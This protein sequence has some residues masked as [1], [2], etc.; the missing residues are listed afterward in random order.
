MKKIN[1]LKLHSSFEKINSLNEDEV[2]VRKLLELCSDSSLMTRELLESFNSKNFIDA[3]KELNSGVKS[4]TL[5]DMS[6]F[7]Y[8]KENIKN[9]EL[10][11][12][13]DD[14]EVY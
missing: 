4:K 13:Q 10:L 1:F 3:M 6:F 11:S 5:Q 9:C 12:I 2:K 14:E 7:E 8:A